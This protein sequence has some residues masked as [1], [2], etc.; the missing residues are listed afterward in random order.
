MAKPSLAKDTSA[1]TFAVRS[2]REQLILIMF[3]CAC[4]LVTKS[5]D[6]DFI[7]AMNFAISDSANHAVFIQENLSCVLAALLKLTL[8]SN[9][10]RFNLLV[11]VLAR[12][13]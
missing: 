9:V 4:Q 8:Q 10:V 5:L 1:K 11:E 6:V 2:R 3:T 13:I 7:L 12:N